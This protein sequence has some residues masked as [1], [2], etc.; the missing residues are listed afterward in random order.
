MKLNSNI[1]I[2]P[3]REGLN[4]L[5]TWI[6][7]LS[8]S[9]LSRPVSVNLLPILRCNSRC[10][11][12]D[13]WRLEET[14]ERLGLDVYESIADDMKDMK[15]PY[16]TIGGGEPMLRGDIYELIE[17]FAKRGISTQLTTNGSKMSLDICRSLIDSGLNRLTF[18]ID[19]H[20][21]E[22]Y[23]KTRGVNWC[24]KV[25]N[26]LQEVIGIY[27][28]QI[29]VETNSVISNINIDSFFDTVK[30]FLSINVNKICF[31]AV[32]ISG[33]NYLIDQGKDDLAGITPEK[34]EEL[35]M[36]LLKAKRDYPKRIAASS[37]F[38]RGIKTYVEN[39]RRAVFPCYAGYLTLDIIYNGNVYS[40]GNLPAL[41]NVR[42]DSISDIWYSKEAMNSRKA[43]GRKR[44]PACY[45]SCKI[46]LALLGSPWRG[47]P[48]CFEKIREAL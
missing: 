44:C 39:P 8:G 17:V 10:V 35:I 4:I 1:K 42:T 21:P 22:I 41:G 32:T 2:N 16:V 46:E 19:S 37:Q 13:S 11:M 7:V 31:S 43:M 27:A 9:M 48:Y 45:T 34:A 15:I 18:S 40:C 12:C 47:I 6:S 5:R 23:E 20:L 29:S 30:Y 25:L 24:A 33:E 14:D 28:D 3:F 36:K 38:I 26:N